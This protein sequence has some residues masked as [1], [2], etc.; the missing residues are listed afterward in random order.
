MAQNFIEKQGEADSVDRNVR[1][2]FR[3]DW[4][5]EKDIHSDF[6]SDWLRK[7]NC[8]GYAICIYFMTMG[9]LGSGQV[10]G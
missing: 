2:K 8:I 5:T 3:F 1:N 9:A 6:L 4:L 10:G 7:R